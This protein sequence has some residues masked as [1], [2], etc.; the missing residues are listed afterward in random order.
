[1]NDYIGP[2]YPDVTVPLTGIDG[3]A[4]VIIAT[5]AKALRDNGYG[6][7]VADYRDQAMSGDYNNVLTTTMLWVNVE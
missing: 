1:M 5:V 7:E 2:R 6:H 3:N 4:M